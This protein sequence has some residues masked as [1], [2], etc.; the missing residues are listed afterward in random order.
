MREELI[1]WKEVANHL[2]VNVRTA[3]RWER[4]RALPVRRLAGRGGHLVISRVALDAWQR[5]AK[6][7]PSHSRHEVACYRWPL[8]S[9]VTAELRLH[10]APITL[11]HLNRLRQ[12]LDLV[13]QSLQP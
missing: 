8:S 4:E 3:Q 1:T 12:Y 2:G 10:G 11:D 9:L 13:Q 7:N 5:T 6:S